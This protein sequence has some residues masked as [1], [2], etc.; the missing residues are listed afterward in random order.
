MLIAQAVEAVVFGRLQRAHVRQESVPGAGVRLLLL[1]VFWGP[2]DAAVVGRS[3]TGVMCARAGVMCERAG[4]LCARA[5]VLCARAGVLCAGAGVSCA[6]V[7]MAGVAGG[8]VVT[9]AKGL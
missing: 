2:L 7:G 9:V 1:G 3:A 5:R 8:G 6:R 4:V